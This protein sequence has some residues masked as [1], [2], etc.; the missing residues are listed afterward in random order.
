MTSFDWCVAYLFKL[1]SH[2]SVNAPCSLYAPMTTDRKWQ[3]HSGLICFI[4]LMVNMKPSASHSLIQC[5]HCHVWNW[6]DLSSA[7][8]QLRFSCTEPLPIDAASKVVVPWHLDMTD[9]R[10]TSN[11]DTSIAMSRKWLWFLPLRLVPHG[12]NDENIC[13]QNHSPYKRVASTK[14]P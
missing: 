11:G 12:L 7:G 8:D 13:G 3:R 5:I 14:T 6:R 10:R 2:D 1:H 9:Y 4:E